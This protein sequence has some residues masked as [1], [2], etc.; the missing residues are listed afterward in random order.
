MNL[1]PNTQLNYNFSVRI[2]S[3]NPSIVPTLNNGRLSMR[4]KF[5][6]SPNVFHSIPAKAYEVDNNTS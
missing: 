4:T 6:L 2:W 3:T 1:D 5:F